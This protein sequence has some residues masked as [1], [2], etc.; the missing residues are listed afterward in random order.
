MYTT[1]H[2][3][4]VARLKCTQF[5]AGSEVMLDLFFGDKV[6][7]H[8]SMYHIS[9]LQTVTWME[10]YI[11]SLSAL[12]H[13]PLTPLKLSANISWGRHTCQTRNYSNTD[14][15]TPVRAKNIPK[16]PLSRGRK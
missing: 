15:Y 10:I 16:L 12:L 9:T 13:V 6:G 8:S 2:T 7:G 3:C 4:T 5:I 11:T 1:S 14:M